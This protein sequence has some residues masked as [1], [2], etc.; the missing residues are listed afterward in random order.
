MPFWCPQPSSN[1]PQP[2]A[3][4]CEQPPWQ[5]AAVPVG[6][7]AKGVIF[8]CFKCCV[9]SF[10]VAGKAL[11]DMWTRDRRAT[12]AMPLGEVSKGV[13]F[14]ACFARI[15]LAGLREVVTKCKFW[16][17]VASCET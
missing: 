3:T 5:K 13:I 10:R 7:V 16:A 4:V 8:G 12:T 17:G 11:R 9:A 2:F 6:K 1:R 14:V 15:A